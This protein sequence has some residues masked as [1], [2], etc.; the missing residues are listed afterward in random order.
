MAA[1]LVSHSKRNTYLESVRQAGA[2]DIF[3]SK[4]EE[5][6]RGWIE[7]LNVRHSHS[8][9]KSVDV[10][11]LKKDGRPSSQRCAITC[12]VDKEED[13]LETDLRSVHSCMDPTAGQEVL[14]GP[15]VDIVPVFV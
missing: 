4:T 2:E 11:R 5:V 10:Y 1:K 7:L 3:G 14:H 8:Q 6:T 15:L 9:Q 12:A 13:R